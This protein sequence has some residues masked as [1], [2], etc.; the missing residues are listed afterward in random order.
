LV[1]EGVFDG[2]LG[3]EE[4]SKIEERERKRCGCVYIGG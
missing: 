4:E 1:F 3:E 2:E